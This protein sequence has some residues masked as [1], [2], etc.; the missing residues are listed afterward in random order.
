MD[1]SAQTVIQL[2][3]SVG[4]AP[5]ACQASRPPPQS[6]PPPSSEAMAPHSQH[7]S[8]R[9]VPTLT[10]SSRPCPCIKAYFKKQTARAVD[11]PDSVMPHLAHLPE[12]VQGQRRESLVDTYPSTIEFR[13]TMS[14]AGI[15]SN[16]L[17]ASPT[18]LRQCLAWRRT[19]LE[20]Y[21]ETGIWRR[22]HR[23]G[24]LDARST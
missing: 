5:L 1:V 16:T 19:R 11:N 7:M 12:A 17:S 20:S 22:G 23:R 9:E 3:E 21:A 13:V 8:R 18:M 2:K 24:R 10:S 15:P 6:S 14:L 4:D